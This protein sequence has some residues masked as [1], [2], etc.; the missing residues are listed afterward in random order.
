MK[1]VDSC[2]NRVF[3]DALLSSLL[4]FVFCAPVAADQMWT[5]VFKDCLAKAK[6]GKSDAQ[7]QVG[8]M[9]LKG[10]G[11]S[12]DREQ[13]I[14]WLESAAHAG[15]Q[16]ASSKLA[17]IKEQ[18]S[19]FKEV[20][21][22]A[23]AGK[24]DAQYEL[25]MMYLKGRG[26][27]A[28]GNKARKWLDKAAGTGDEKAITRL[29]IINYKGEGGSVD[30]GRALSLFNKVR[31]KSVLAQYYLGEMYAEGA[32]TAKNYTTAIKWY[33]KAAEGGFN[34]AQ[35]KIIN[36]QEEIRVEKHRK[37]RVASVAK[38]APPVQTTARPAPMVVAK[39]EPVAPPPRHAQPARVVAKAAVRKVARAP[40]SDL[41]SLATEDWVRNKRPVD[42]LPSHVTQC[43]KEDGALVCLS[44]VL[45]RVTGPQTVTYRVKSFVRSHKGSINISYRNLVLDVTDAEEQDDA[46]LGYDGE[47]EKG[48]HI[49]TGWTP[50]HKVTCSYSHGKMSCV[51]DQAYKM[52]LV[53]EK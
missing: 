12:Q 2:I 44:K 7:Y 32:G 23:Q 3:R 27:P 52:S 35:G 26:V 48:F 53:A 14:K 10:Q 11:V 16:M 33:K 43:D 8:I 47:T 19:R 51:K 28:D 40:L 41:D 45:K 49:Q 15:Y 20:Q 24:V 39:N 31:E 18:E 46:P 1:S 37:T 5:G 21:D 22:K 25:A 42:Y 29:G 50:E 13:G 30:Y 4:V 9:Y 38:P 17:R 36:L 6:N 34:R